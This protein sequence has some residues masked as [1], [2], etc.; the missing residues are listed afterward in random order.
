MTKPGNIC[1]FPATVLMNH[2]LAYGNILLLVLLSYYHILVL[3]C[4]FEHLE[5]FGAQFILRDVWCQS[6][7]FLMLLSHY[8]AHFARLFSPHFGK[9]SRGTF[10]LPNYQV[11]RVSDLFRCLAKVFKT[12]ACVQTLKSVFKGRQLSPKYQTPP[13]TK[14]QINAAIT[15]PGFGD[16]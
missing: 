14:D 12:S 9:N 7:Q 13:C 15:N 1:S 3:S 4:F 16:A 5:C 6:R 10:Q 2:Q 8:S 11:K